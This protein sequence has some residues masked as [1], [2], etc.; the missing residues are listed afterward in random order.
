[1]N[2]KKI[3]IYEFDILF[4]ILSEIKE[5]FG[6]DL[7]KLDKNN[8]ENKNFFSNPDYL[9][10]SKEDNDNFENHLKI[11]KIPIKI[12][13]LIESINLRFLKKRF[14]LQSEI[15]VKDYKL[16]LNSRKISLKDRIIDLTEREINLILFL[17]KSKN[18]VKIDKL[19]KEVW[20]YNPELETH[21]VETHI[22]R[23]RKKM[24]EK[25]DDENFILST[26]KGYKIN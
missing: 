21:T 19:Q 1:M 26:K 22:Y 11:E 25:F 2:F 18:S 7:V 8:F 10:I 16:N 17:L 4:N 20:G 12:S 5:N 3:F 14:N 9:V 15:M 6:F 24:K 13:E 23:L